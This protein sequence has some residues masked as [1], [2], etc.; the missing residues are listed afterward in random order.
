MSIVN[1]KEFTVEKDGKEIKLS[2]V[3]PSQAIRQ[4]SEIEYA[5]AWGSYAKE[6]GILLETALWDTLRKKKLWDD[7]RQNELNEIDK[8]MSESEKLLPDENGK[9]KQKGVTLSMARKAAIQMRVDRM[10]RVVLLSD[11]TKLRSNT[12][13]GL[14]EN[15]K[16]NYLV[17]QCVLTDTGKPYFNSLDNYLER[18]ND[19]D[20]ETAASEFANLYY[21]YNKDFDKGLPENAF[22]LKHKMCRDKDLALT[23]KNGD[24]VDVEGNPIDEKGDRLDK[25]KESDEVYEVEDDWD[26]KTEPKE[27]VKIEE[28]KEVVV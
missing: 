20:A 1:K 14:S 25:V 8:R 21:D 19:K 3:R 10:K 9:V 18:A 13:E 24:L 2:V 16:F 22:L 17:S 23:N 7:D 27:E 26:K 6:P 4:R 15:S 5:K 11:V 28:V 12:A